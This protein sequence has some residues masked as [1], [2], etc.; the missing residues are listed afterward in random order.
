MQINSIA[1]ARNW[2]G[3]Q[4]HTITAAI[5]S[6]ASV[7][8]ETEQCFSCIL[9]NRMW[10]T[11]RQLNRRTLSINGCQAAV[12]IADR[13]Q[14]LLDEP[15]GRLV[16]TMSAIYAM[17]QKG[18]VWQRVK[19]VATC[20]QCA[21]L[22]CLLA[23]MFCCSQT[24]AQLIHYASRQLRMRPSLCLSRTNTTDWYSCISCQFQLHRE[25]VSSIV[26]SSVGS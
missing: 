3:R 4:R 14:L 25:T 26:C 5:A 13:M 10:V 21:L 16:H 22:I 18:K 1:R 6:Y 9:V 15:R 24:A 12:V 19:V 8:G 11:R 7:V 2:I 20:E 17:W 23:F